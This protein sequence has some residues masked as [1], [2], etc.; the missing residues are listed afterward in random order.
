MI[1]SVSRVRSPLVLRGLC[2]LFSLLFLLHAFRS[3]RTSAV[4]AYRQYFDVD[5]IL[6][7]SLPEFAVSVSSVL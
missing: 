2:L 4:D 7:S 6:S 3:C 1:G 5:I